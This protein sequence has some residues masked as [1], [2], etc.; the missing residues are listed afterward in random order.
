MAARR[1]SQPK[2]PWI[3]RLPHGLREQGAWVFIGLMVGLAG[4]SYMLGISQ[5]NITQ[6][7]GTTGLRIWGAFLAVSGFGVVYATMRARSALEK[8]ALRVLSICM[9]VYT[10]WLTVVAPL[11]R[12]VMTIV[13]VLA[14]VLMSEIRIAFIKVLLRGGPRGD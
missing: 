9:L 7:V 11:G 3:L 8:L 1:R 14:L 4:V 6:A 5:S 10:G 13:L 2:L 12:L